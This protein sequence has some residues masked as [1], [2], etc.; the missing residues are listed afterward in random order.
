LPPLP[1]SRSFASDVSWLGNASI[2][3]FGSSRQFIKGQ[4]GSHRAI[5]APNM[6]PEGY[7]G[8]FTRDYSYGLVHTPWVGDNT[9]ATT[10]NLTLETFMWASKQL[11]LEQ[12]SDGQMPDVIFGGGKSGFNRCSDQACTF[13]AGSPLPRPSCCGSPSHPKNCSDGSMDSAPFTVFNVLFLARR[14]KAEQGAAAAAAWLGKWLPTLLRALERTPSGPNGSAL[15]Y[16]D[17]RDPI[18]GYGF[19]DSVAKTGALNFA[20]L[21]TLEACATLC[22]ASRS[23]GPYDGTNTIAALAPATEA[24]CRRATNISK[25]LTTALWDERVGMFHPSTGL[26]GNL[27]DIWGSAYA[28]SLDGTHTILGVDAWPSDVPA[29]TTTAQRQRII[30]FLADQRNGIFV[31]GQVRHLPM[32]QGWEQ[33][34]CVPKGAG[35]GQPPCAEGWLYSRP[36]SYQNGGA[37]IMLISL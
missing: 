20:S 10:W 24:L 23:H 4:D 6:Q 14:L 35:A 27:T 5:F 15:A 17:P 12:R 19:E 36:G 25:Q 21:L 7:H 37:C 13:P 29:P 31:A 2:Y 30:D 26:E 16:N 28:A 34:W 1:A 3:V 22:H 33:E 8:E 9:A 32:G 11:L 18:V